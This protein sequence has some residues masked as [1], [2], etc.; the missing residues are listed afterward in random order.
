M[1]G[2]DVIS[3]IANI[4]ALV[5]FSQKILA[6]AAELH[7]S[8]QDVGEAFIGINN[9]LPPINRTIKKTKERIENGEIDEETAKS[10]LPVHQ[11]V[12]RTLEELKIILDKFSPKAD[13]PKWDVLWKATRSVFQ[14][15]KVKGI[16]QRL[17]EYVGIL[18]LS[19]A[20]L[21]S[22]GNLSLAERANIQQ[23]LANISRS[24]TAQ[25]ASLPRKCRNLL[26]LDGGGLRGLSILYILQDLMA[27]VNKNQD[28]PLK[29]CE[30]FDLIGG[31]GTGG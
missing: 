25:A 22:A 13:A 24:T 12:E 31:S 17:H 5:D 19:H 11:G 9:M 28:L 26:S 14:E 27:K 4:I 8:G 10:L 23:I 15:K 6:R 30:V 21:A 1:S 16:L 7:A 29:P 18:T 3:V 20:E 2:L